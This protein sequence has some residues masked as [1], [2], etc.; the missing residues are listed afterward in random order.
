MK[1]KHNITVLG[2]GS[3]GTALAS[4][5]ARAGHDVCV[6][7]NEAEVLAEISQGRNSRYFPGD[8]VASGI[9]T[10]PSLSSAFSET[11]LVVVA[12]PSFAV[13]EVVE[14]AKGF[15]ERTTVVSAGK[16]LEGGSFVFLSDV[17]A[18]VLGDPSRVAVLSGPSFALEVLRG[19]PTAVTVASTREETAKHVAEVFH[20]DSFRVYTTSDVAGVEVGGAVKN[21][22]ALAVGMVDGLEGGANSRAALITR[23]LAEIAR[24]ANALGG[25]TRTVS[26]LSGLGDLL[27]TATGDLSRNRTVG[28]R[29]G[30]G[31]KLPEILQSIGQVAEGVEAAPKILELA[32]RHG[33]TMPI[34][35]QV[36]KVIS[37]ESSVGDSAR[38]LLSRERKGET[39]S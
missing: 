37:G 23:G 4:H 27:L 6:W 12:V 13:R 28:L 2:C 36:V 30:R 33:V 3:W 18:S 5:L 8:A 24:L 29:L 35:E 7:G 10:T 32:S 21:V 17:I 39:S 1:K 25:D 16:G 26:G 38:A 20:F 34:T 31:E 22:I 19:K 9:R 15:L 14:S 11:D